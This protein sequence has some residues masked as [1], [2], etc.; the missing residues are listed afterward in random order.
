MQAELIAIG[1]EL[2]L[3]AVPNDNT[4]YLARILAGLGISCY[5]HLTIG[6]NPGRLRE[7]VESALSRADLVI[8]CG[9]LGPTVDDVTLETLAQA[10]G[11]PLTLNRQVLRRIQRGFRN[12]SIRMP[13]AAGRQALLP[14]GAVCL[15]NRIG[16]APGFMLKLTW[17][18]GAPEHRSTEQE[19]FKLLIALPGPPW[20]L[21]P[22]VEEQLLRRLKP[23]AGQNVIQSRTLKITGLTEPAVDQKVKDLLQLSGATTVGIYSRPGQVNLTLTARARGA[24]AASRQIAGLERKIRS[25]LG[26]WIFGADQE[27]LEG[28]VGTLLKTRGWTVGVAE[29]C[30]G[31]L[32]QHRITEVAGSSDYFLGGVV[33][34]AN[35]LK[36]APLTVAPSLLKR[37]GAVS[38]PVARAMARGV[39][40]LTQADIGLSLTGIAGPTG[41]SKTKPVGL[42]Y[43]GLS[44]AEGSRVVRFRFPGSRPMVKFRASQAALNLLRRYC[45]K[46]S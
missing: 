7:A 27:T 42:V 2:L 13:A 29:S 30:T 39:R 38:A 41:G 6:D 12:R 43:I 45:L 10:A 26:K 19:A 28:A 24:A 17:R 18:T 14:K 20:E 36:E 37:H 5:R 22:M 11:R 25:R 15:P 46:A 44:S 33:A 21:I 40:D 32:V 3:G 34:Y 31:G 23:Y 8:T 35:S 9:G 16:T 1:T 4:A